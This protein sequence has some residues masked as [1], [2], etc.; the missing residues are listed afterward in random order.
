MMM[1]G[2]N[3]KSTSEKSTFT[4]IRG[5]ENVDLQN[6][7]NSSC[8]LEITRRNGSNEILKFRHL[9]NRGL[10]TPIELFFEIDYYGMAGSGTCT[11]R[12]LHGLKSQFSVKRIS[13]GKEKKGI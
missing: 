11:N 1:Y 6:F 13:T 12:K 3:E 5:L 8:G 9:K 2:T 4:E 10:K 7:G